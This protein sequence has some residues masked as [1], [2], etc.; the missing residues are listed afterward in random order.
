MRGEETQMLGIASGGG[1]TLIVTPGTHSKWAVMCDGRIEGFRTYMTGE[2]Y[3]LLTTHS[4]LARL[5]DPTTVGEI[6][7]ATFL[8]GV[9]LGLEE[10]ALLHSLFSVRTHALF[11][12]RPAARLSSFLSGILIG[13]EVGAERQRNALTAAAVTVIA[14]SQ[15]ARL[16]S[17]ALAAVGCGTV[18]RIDSDV[19]VVRGLWRIW[20]VRG[21]A[22]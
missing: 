22:A 17:I 4:S 2:I 5:M 7:E 8:E 20:G 9:H 13:N 10:P 1:Q 19:A 3:A 18:Q 15:L 6:D 12:R 11:G 16:Y 21:S 14:G